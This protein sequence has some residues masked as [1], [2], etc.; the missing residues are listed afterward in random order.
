MD[1]IFDRP[2]EDPA[3]K[4]G[5]TISAEICQRLRSLSHDHEAWHDELDRLHDLGYQPEIVLLDTGLV[6]ELLGENRTNFLDLFRAIAEFDGYKAGKLMIE[7]CKSPE[8]V[9]DSETFALK[10]QHLALSVKSRTFSL[11]QIRV[12][13]VLSEVLKAVRTHHVRMEGDFINTILSIL[14]LEGIGRQLDPDMDL[15]KG[16]LPI[17]RQLGK[18]MGTSGTLKDQLKD[19]LS[20]GTLGPMLKV[21]LSSLVLRFQ[22]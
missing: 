4:Q 7:R 6:T 16:A 20:S 19:G 3:A 5:G 13:D 15:F 10:I 17:L 9:L 21:S 2:E 22:N 18:Q 12:S 8:L 11:S 1:R 14:L